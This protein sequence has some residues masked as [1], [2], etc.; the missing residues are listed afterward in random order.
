MIRVDVI[1]ILLRFGNLLEITHDT[2]ENSL[3]SYNIV[4]IKSKYYK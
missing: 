2:V 1:T 4:K 3:C